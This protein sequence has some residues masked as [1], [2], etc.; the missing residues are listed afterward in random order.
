MPVMAVNNQNQE[1]TGD[2]RSRPRWS[3]AKKRVFVVAERGQQLRFFRD[4]DAKFT[5]SFDD[6]FRLTSR[7]PAPPAQLGAPHIR[8]N[9]GQDTGLRHQRIGL[10]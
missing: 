6:V 7:Y 10:L 8:S 2:Y 9:S 4:R 5:R 1:Q 3:A